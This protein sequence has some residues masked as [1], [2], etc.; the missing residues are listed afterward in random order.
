MDGVRR[1]DFQQHTGWELDP[2]MGSELQ[3][4][5]ELGLLEDDGRT[6]R[7]TRRGLMVSDAIWPY[8]LAPG[9]SGASPSDPALAEPTP[10]S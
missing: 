5:Q 9:E 7:L 8:L 10:N 2:L 6:I 3:R 4:F 1:L